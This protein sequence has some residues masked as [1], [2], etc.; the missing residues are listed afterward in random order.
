[1]RIETD[2]IF[3]VVPLAKDGLPRKVYSVWFIIHAEEESD[4]L[5]FTVLL[6]GS[7]TVRKRVYLKESP[8]AGIL[9]NLNEE[10][11]ARRVQPSFAV[12]DCSNK[13]IY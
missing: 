10:Y 8:A 7:V 5:R 11:G 4:G 9:F 12:L 1:L 3:Y 2:K 6:L 13:V